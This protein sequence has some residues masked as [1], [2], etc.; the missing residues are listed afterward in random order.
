MENPVGYLY[1]VGTTRSTPQ[2]APL[3]LPAPESIGVPDIEPALI[4]ALLALPE[5]Q[6]AAVW[7]VHSCQWTYAEVA[8][9]LG[10]GTST[11]GTHVSRA[12]AALRSELE[13]AHHG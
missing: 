12:L 8:E 1:R 11:V 4:P 9:A 7:L 13:V 3:T 2:R 10:I 5:K 6:R